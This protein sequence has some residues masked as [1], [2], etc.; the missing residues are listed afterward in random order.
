MVGCAPSRVA[1]PLTRT[2]GGSSQDQQ[3]EFWNKLSERP[4]TCNDEA[5]HGLL[6]YLYDRDPAES[7]AD[8]VRLLKSK[9]MLPA[10]FNR[11]AEEAVSRGVLA[12]A[13]AEALHIRGGLLMSVFGNNPRYALLEL[14]DNGLFPPSSENQTF[15]GTEF[16]GIIGKVEDYQNGDTTTLPASQL[17]PQTG[18]LGGF[19]DH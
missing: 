2:Y 14:Q 10:D 17:N 12:M 7:Y 13:V 4:L 9:K 6:L 16:A 8:R 11:P 1:D 5:F 15:S 3:F 18:R 19:T